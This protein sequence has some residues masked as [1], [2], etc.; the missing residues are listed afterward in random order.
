MEGKETEQAIISSS[1]LENEI[2]ELCNAE[3]FLKTTLKSIPE[4]SCGYQLAKAQL[5]GVEGRL[6]E[7][8]IHEVVLYESHNDGLGEIITKKKLRVSDAGRW[9]EAQQERESKK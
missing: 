6:E 9:R 3:N 7:L 4:G 8:G 5:K 2:R 1:G